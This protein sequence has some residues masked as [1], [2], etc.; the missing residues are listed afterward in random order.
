MVNRSLVGYL[1]NI[2]LILAFYVLLTDFRVNLSCPHRTVA[3]DLLNN[4]DVHAGTQKVGSKRVPQDMRMDALGYFSAFAEL[5]YKLLYR[6]R[7]EPVIR[8][9]RAA[10]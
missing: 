1:S 7:A 3:K 5:A 6:P 10:E 2:L 9:P 8:C 4:G